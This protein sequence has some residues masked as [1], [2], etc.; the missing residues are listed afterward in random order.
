[1]CGAVCVFVRVWGTKEEQLLPRTEGTPFQK[2]LRPSLQKLRIAGGV[3]RDAASKNRPHADAGLDKAGGERD[4]KSISTTKRENK[5]DKK[6]K[7]GKKGP[8]PVASDEMACTNKQTKRVHTHAREGLHKQTNKESPP[9]L[10]A[11]TT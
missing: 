10:Q 1:M 2:K 7:K 5:M 3:S 8:K 4:T 6:G 9:P 11:T